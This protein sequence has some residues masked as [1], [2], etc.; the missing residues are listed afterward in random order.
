MNIDIKANRNNRKY[1]K[2]EIIRRLL[3]G[4]FHP[5]FRFSPRSFFSWRRF[6]LRIFGAKV[7]K[8]VHVYNSARIY[9]PWNLIINDW[10]AIGEDSLIYNLGLITIGKK[11]T[12]SYRSHV[13]SGTHDFSKNDLPLLKSTVKIDDQAWI[14]TDV[15][16][17]P[18]VCV[19]EGALIG[20]RTV[21]VKDVEPWTVVAGNPA[22]FIRKRI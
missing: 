13:C 4:L 20:A 11:V 7:G 21:V 22:K 5:L 1:S 12:L 18:G 2:S 14:G 16:I 9:M 15:F 6:I 8:E 10:S 17:G 19:G 3:W